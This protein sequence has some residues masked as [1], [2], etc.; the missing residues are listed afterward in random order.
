MSDVVI[1]VENLSKKY[2]IRHE[3]KEPYIA[4]RD[5]LAYKAKSIGQRVIAPFTHSSQRTTQCSKEEFWA[6]KNISFEISE[7]ERVGIIGR[8]GAGK[9]T[10]LKIL[11]RITNLLRGVLL[12][13]AGWQA[14]WKLV[15]DFIR[16]RI[17]SKIRQLRHD[18][19]DNARISYAQCGED[20][21]IQYL[22]MTLGISKI[23]Y[24]DIG[25]YHPTYMSNTYLFYRSGGHGVCVEPDL[26]L[27]RQFRAKR[28]R[29]I[30]LNCGVGVV[31][32]K[33]DFFVMSNSTL[34]TFSK[35][36]VEQYQS[37][38]KQRI[39]KTI[40]TELKTINEIIEQHVEKCPNL[41]SLDTEG[42]DYLILQNFDFKKYRPEVFCVETLTY[43]EDKSERKLKEIIE[44]MHTHDY[45]SYADTYINTI[46]VDNTA[47][48]NRP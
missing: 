19:S 28:P 17:L 39:E 16:N 11:S 26:S 25:A 10:L 42:M 47:W 44:L 1:K 13:M 30:H 6:L 21:I 32:E 3:Q 38:G 23:V 20:L 18:Y 14:F 43:A 22:F 5:V 45:F 41:I 2:L 37:Q 31:S 36:E 33:A 7:G 27:F 12:S 46:F 24:L 4:L 48:N 34:N 9:T 15:P 8:N 29:D 40:K 35:A